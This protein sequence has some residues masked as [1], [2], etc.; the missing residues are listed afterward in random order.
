MPEIKLDVQLI[1]AAADILVMAGDKILIYNGLA[2]GVQP[3]DGC[4]AE[5][6]SPPRTVKQPR[7]S[8]IAIAQYDYLRQKIPALLREAGPLSSYDISDRIGFGRKDTN[9]RASVSYWLRRLMEIGIVERAPT[10][11][12]RLH[13][14]QL[15]H[16]E[17]DH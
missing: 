3:K 9:A 13:I 11:R 12:T 15:K 17:A 16:P 8:G 4:F 10:A 7:Q 14:Y 5:V 1:T 6:K 2:I